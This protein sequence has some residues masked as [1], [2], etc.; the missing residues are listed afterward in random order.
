MT[1]GDRKF[2]K[3][4]N[5]FQRFITKALRGDKILSTGIYNMELG[6]PTQLASRVCDLRNVFGGELAKADI[7]S[8]TLGSKVPYFLSL[9][10]NGSDRYILGV[11]VDGKFFV[12]ELAHLEIS[13]KTGTAS[14]TMTGLIELA[15]SQWP[16]PGDEPTL[17]NSGS[18][19]VLRHLQNA[20]ASDSNTKDCGIQDIAFVVEDGVPSFLVDAQG[21]PYLLHMK[22]INCQERVQ[23]SVTQ[24]PRWQ[25]DRFVSTSDTKVVT[26]TNGAIDVLNDATANFRSPPSTSM[27]CGPVSLRSTFQKPQAAIDASRTENDASNMSLAIYIFGGALVLTIIAA[28]V[29]LRLYLGERIGNKKRDIETKHRSTSTTGIETVAL[30]EEQQVLVVSEESGEVAKLSDDVQSPLSATFA[31]SVAG[32]NQ[33][34][35]LS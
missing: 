15:K 21:A 8:Y 25:I 14:F 27:P 23:N 10:Y 7:K 5:G 12:A 16:M 1:R 26:I 22:P 34:Q 6:G 2:A 35:T 11:E 17:S 32:N 4:F 20:L 9:R 33:H 30:P 19:S 13:A 29:S 3:F 28:F 31:S 18:N 24:K